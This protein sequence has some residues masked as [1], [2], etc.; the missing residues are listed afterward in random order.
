MMKKFITIL[1]FMFSTLLMN[2][3]LWAETQLVLENKSLKRVFS[4]TDE[5]LQTTKIINTNFKKATPSSS[6]IITNLP[7][8]I[9]R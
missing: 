3:P 8:K 6:K 5:T 2:V 9:H 4:V 7:E 1:S